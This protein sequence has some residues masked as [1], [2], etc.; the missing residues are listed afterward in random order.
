MADEKVDRVAEMMAVDDEAMRGR[1]LPEAV[2]NA[3]A[4]EDKKPPERDESGKFKGDDKKTDKAED[5]P[6]VEEK[7]KETVPLATFLEKTNKL[8]EQLDQKD[9]TLKQY[10]T[11]LA[12]LEAKTAPKPEVAPEPDFI[13]D[14]KGYVDH[15]LKAA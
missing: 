5:K 6:K 7:P 4:P 9:I 2:V 10:E 8:K 11:R 3:E 12:A 13:E 14:P 15:N 1:E